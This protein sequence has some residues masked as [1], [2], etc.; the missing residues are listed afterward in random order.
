MPRAYFLEALKMAV[1]RDRRLRI[2]NQ[3]PNIFFLSIYSQTGA[4]L[5][6]AA[7]ID[8]FAETIN[9]CLENHPIGFF[10]CDVDSL[11][12][13]TMVASTNPQGVRGIS[14]RLSSEKPGEPSK[15]V[16]LLPKFS[17]LRNL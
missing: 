5:E 8:A 1:L 6:C 13:L 9:V 17:F 16:S 2:M 3:S 10:S 12:F 15:I 7:G 14:Y 4:R 11:A